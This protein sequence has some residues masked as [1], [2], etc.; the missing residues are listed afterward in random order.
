MIIKSLKLKNYRNHQ[1]F[2][3]IPSDETNLLIGDNGTGKTNV[4]EA[5]NVLSTTK[6]FR[7]RYDRDLI[8][9]GKEF[10]LIESKVETPEGIDDLQLQIIKTPRSHKTSK[11]KV[12]INNVAKSLNN[13]THHLKSVLF[14]PEDI[15]V[16][17]GSPSLRRK[18][19]DM[20]LYQAEGN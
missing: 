3:L 4:L 19:V 13:F 9:Y 12:K 17:T 6:S 15:D 18:F 20:L 8:S 14:T 11:K 10:A 16:I 1:N 7:A 5:V 2:H